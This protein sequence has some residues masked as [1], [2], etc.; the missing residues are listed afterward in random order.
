ME[1]KKVEEPTITLS[2]EKIK[3]TGKP[4]WN[5]ALLMEPFENGKTGNVGYNRVKLDY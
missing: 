2:N 4:K 5:T 1:T 3:K